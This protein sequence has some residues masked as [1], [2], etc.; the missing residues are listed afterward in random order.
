MKKILLLLLLA[1]NSMVL[2]AQHLYINGKVTDS[3]KKTIE[4]ATVYL[5]KEKDSSIVNYT[6]TNKEGKF[7]LKTDALNEPSIL[8]ID[9]EKLSI[10][11]KRIEKISQSI[12]LGD[13]E[14]EKNKVQ[15]IE[16]IKITVSPV[17]IKKDTIEFNASAIKVKPDSKIE[18][19]LKQIPG[20][21]VDNDGKI[22]VGGKDVD[23]IM[24]NGK[25]FFDKDGKIALKN[26]P[27]D[28]IKNIQFTTTK[29]KEEELSG[30]SSK[31]NTATINFNIDEKKNK[32]LISRLTLGY[33]SDK[34]YEGS[35][36]LSYFKNDTK[37][38]L[39]ASS[40]NINS[41]GF[42][43]DDVFDSME[44]GRGSSM[45]SGSSGKGIQRST[46]VGINYNDQLGKHIDLD[47]FSLT[48]SNS[49]SETGSKVSRTTLLPEYTLNTRSEN[50][51]ESENQQYNFDT[52]ARIRL[53]SLSSIYFSPKFNSTRSSSF[54]NSTSVTSR[55]QTL[56]NENSSY[57]TTD[58]E[59]NTFTPYIYFLKQFRKKKR[60]FNAKMSST[61]S[62]S[63]NANLNK[64][65]TVFYSG[66]DQNDNRNQLSRSKN[67]NNIYG[68][69]AGYTEPV[70]DSAMVSFE[71]SYNSKMSKN[72][73]DV[74]D[75]NMGSGDYSDYNTPLSNSL[76]QTINQITPQ[77]SFEI[78]KKKFSLWGSMNIDLSDMN[79]NSV[80][81]GQ[82]YSL[83]KNFALP[84][85]SFNFRYS[86]SDNKMLSIYNYSGFTIPGA[87]QLT[88]YEDTS[89]PLITYMG[90]PN[91][92]NAWANNSSLFFNN[93]NIVKN[94]NYY[95][96]INFTYRNN[97]VVNYSR[98]DN[99]GKQLIT[100][101]NISGNKTMSVSGGLSKSFKWN[102][103]KLSINPRFNLQY[104]YNKGFINGQLFTTNSYSLNPGLN[105]TYDLKDK[106]TIK[107]SY[108]I[109]YNFSKYTNYSIDNVNT[110][111][112]SLKLELTNYLFN[113]RLVFGNDFEY[114]TNSNIAPGFKRDFYF[115]N[116]SLGYSFFKKQLTAKMKIYDVLN[117]NQSV[118]RTLSTSYIEDRE[119]LILRR[120][121]MFSLSMKLNRFAGKKMQ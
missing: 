24:I 23:Q 86:F 95:V 70:S 102:D 85:Y 98:Y 20:V 21:E 83:Q 3:D 65:Q 64:S 54:S 39:I 101:D 31:S 100:Y 37:I 19:L 12:S 88:P 93:Y 115:W 113:S 22:T 4:N 81:N 94:M 120:Y 29:T 63:K 111:N 13:I 45:M 69:S 78:N 42:S 77:L 26:L 30:K 66:A 28:I 38:S 33:G 56:L 80:Y 25:P 27:A 2:H 1:F 60:S 59:S 68:F 61:I 104:S 7:S 121:I 53:D 110:A 14:L 44:R 55:D 97:D 92:K 5:L 75:F 57:S 99:S 103:S 89:N 116:T 76:R 72:A 96:S 48:R 47:N 58:S 17:K 10:Y 67:Q 35:T 46:T 105:L 9:A 49:D 84:A 79:V 15:N 32:G 51:S 71:I 91:L 43:N 6:S 8:K 50:K 82:Q 62:E 87:E 107:P 90:N 112:Q 118:R 11:S 106:L 40:N 34:R 108:R 16:E 114:N 36:L 117:Q 74:N 73:R 41:Q 119:D 109:G 18:E 52:S